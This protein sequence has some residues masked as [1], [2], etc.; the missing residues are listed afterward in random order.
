MKCNYLSP[1]KYIYYIFFSLSIFIVWGL[2]LL[3]A[4]KP[5]TW[6][7]FVALVYTFY[8]NMLLR[9]YYEEENNI[10]LLIKFSLPTFYFLALLVM[11]SISWVTIIH[12][13]FVAYTTFFISNFMKHEKLIYSH[14]FVLMFIFVYAFS[15]YNYWELYST[16]KDEVVRYD[17]TKKEEAKKLN[18]FN[19]KV[20][21]INLK[22][23]V[24]LD[25]NLDTITIN[26][27]GKLTLIE[28][29]NEQCVP[30]IAAIRDLEDFYLENKGKFSHYYAYESRRNV[31]Y[32]QDKVFG[33]DP[34]KNKSKIIIDLDNNMYNKLNV[35][36]YPFF[37]IFDENGDLIHAQ[38]GYDS[39]TKITFQ[40]KIL[41]I[42]ADPAFPHSKP[43]T[44]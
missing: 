17:F 15:G 3:D 11:R 41:Q 12:P 38:F 25:S 30:C 44:H 34:I 36:G 10:Q 21:N 7:I 37:L 8:A 22:D 40:Q 42:T 4:D 1:M 39:Q 5:G 35:S 2:L 29:W 19:Y 20:P 27:E 16:K 33:F 31:A 6:G 14:F 24:F 32:Q 43:S 9:K 23:V 28:T 18:L 26:S 13:I